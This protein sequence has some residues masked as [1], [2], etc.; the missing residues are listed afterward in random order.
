MCELKGSTAIGYSYVIEKCYS[1]NSH[2]EHAK[3]SRPADLRQ[4]A[5]STEESS[6]SPPQELCL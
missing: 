6:S 5:Q 1:R 4:K 2:H 3:L